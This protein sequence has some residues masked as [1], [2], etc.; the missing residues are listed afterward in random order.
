[1]TQEIKNQRLVLQAEKGELKASL[2]QATVGNILKELK[3]FFTGYS[4]DEAHRLTI[5]MKDGPTILTTCPALLTRVLANMVKN[6]LEATRNG[7]QVRVWFEMRGGQPCFVVHNPGMIPEQIA[8]QIFKRSFSTK[9]E[10]GRGLGTY[11][12]KL[13]GEQYLGG[14]VGFTTSKEDGTS[15]FIILPPTESEGPL[16]MT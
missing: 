2:M 4:P 9:G 8:L 10:P 1:M 12:M 5:A 11:S 16:L 14:N 6:A 3:S 13:F 15:F 7:D